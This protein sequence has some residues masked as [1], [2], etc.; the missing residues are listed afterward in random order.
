M[1]FGQSLHD[2]ERA[3]AALRR[4]GAEA[5]G[6]SDQQRRLFDQQRM[7]P[8]VQAGDGLAATL[9]TA[10]ETLARALSAL[11]GYP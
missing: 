8:L 11:R 3:V 1:G 7:Q 2:V 5:T 4:A 9:R 10:D 6:W